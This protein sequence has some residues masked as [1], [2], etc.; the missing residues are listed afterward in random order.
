MPAILVIPVSNYGRL[1]ELIKFE[2]A[3]FYLLAHFPTTSL[4]SYALTDKYYAESRPNEYT[5]DLTRFNNTL[6]G[7]K[8]IM[9]YTYITDIDQTSEYAKM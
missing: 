6:G 9:D 3:G 2:E 1:Q 4:A 8:I 7:L 5:F